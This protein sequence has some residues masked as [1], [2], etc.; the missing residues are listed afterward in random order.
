MM[1]S[2]QPLL[3]AQQIFIL[4]A[5]AHY[6]RQGI[7]HM[8]TYDGYYNAELSAAIRFRLHDISMS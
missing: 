4:C 6:L 1:I 3:L 8:Y 2:L 5:P 7:R